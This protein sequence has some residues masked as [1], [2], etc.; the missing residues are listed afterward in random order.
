MP[1]RYDSVTRQ[2]TVEVPAGEEQLVEIRYAEIEPGRFAPLPL[3]PR[4]EEIPA[5]EGLEPEHFAPVPFSASWKP[6]AVSV[7]GNRETVLYRADFSGK[8]PEWKFHSW[9]KSPSPVSGGLTGEN[10]RPPKAL[11]IRAVDHDYAGRVSPLIPLPAGRRELVLRGTLSLSPDYR[12]NKPRMFFWSGK[13]AHFFELPRPR[14]GTKQRFEIVLPIAKL[15][16]GTGGVHL[17]LVSSF[18][19]GTEEPAGSVFFHDLSLSCR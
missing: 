9:G 15:P 10:G 13:S 14:P 7:G 5:A 19:G 1:Y 16:A 18:T 8:T 17:Q 4:P 2:V 12:N 11:A 3:P 6:S